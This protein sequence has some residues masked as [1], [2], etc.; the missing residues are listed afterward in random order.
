M[1]C[2]KCKTVHDG[3]FG[4]GRFCSRSCANSRILT[5]KTKK[6]IS[7][8]LS[9][10]LETICC[11]NCKK[12]VIRK[13]AGHRKFCSQLC[14]V[15]FN[16]KNRI[17][18]VTDITRQKNADTLIQQ[19]KNG[20]KVMGGNTKWINVDTSIGK[21]KVQGTYE[22]RT[23]RILDIL[24]RINY[25]NDW[26]YTNDRIEYTG[27]DNKQHL[28][29]LDFKIFNNDL[30]FKYIEVKGYTREIDLLKWNEMKKLKI[31]FEVWFLNDII[32]QE[33]ELLK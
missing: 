23:C 7:N 28:Y 13:K 29:L 10:G 12:N 6:K 27:K 8:T 25:I 20:R 11:A 24:K 9:F 5:K 26:E 2:E 1:I 3:T 16:N 22:V 19:Y 17:R 14:A 33:K 32:K 4:S 18:I 21:L 15:I 30:S 31:P